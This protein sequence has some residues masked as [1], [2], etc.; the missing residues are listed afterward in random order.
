MM[1]RLTTIDR[2]AAEIAELYRQGKIS[3]VNSV[4][5]F[6]GCGKRLQA[7][8]DS[9]SH[10]EWLPWLADNAEVLK[11]DTA[12]TAQRLMKLAA[13]TTS[14]VAFD[15]ASALAVSRQLWG[16]DEQQDDG[17]NDDIDLDSLLRDDEGELTP[18]ARDFIREVKREKSDSKKAVRVAR[19]AALA[20][21]QLAL[22]QKKYG[23][24]YADP[25]WKFEV[26]SEMWMSTSH[27]A[28]HYT[29]SPT[30]EIAARPVADIAAED[31][32]LFLWATV[33]MLP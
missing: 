14:N 2:D 4:Q 8:K 32:V 12:R 27:P 13:N 26:G 11:F 29:T 16:N 9:L 28:N 3:L 22:P 19:E 7:K 5:Y 20:S 31:C 10:G 18:K 1:D 30:E 25:E 17:A 33:P 6:I 24:I 21:K 15:E 23:V